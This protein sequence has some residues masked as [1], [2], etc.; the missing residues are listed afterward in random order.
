[1][2]SSKCAKTKPAA[3]D[4]RDPRLNAAGR[5]SWPTYYVFT[6][7]AVSKLANIY[8]F[9]HPLNE[10]CKEA[11]MFIKEFFRQWWSLLDSVQL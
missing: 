6:T 9:L 11:D 1:M 4:T 8:L 3:Y 7:Y 5:N 10:K 2:D